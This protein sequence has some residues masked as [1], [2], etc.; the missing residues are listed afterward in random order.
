MLEFN[1]DRFLS[2]L[3]AAP[4][5]EPVIEEPEHS[6]YV[7][8]LIDTFKK[9]GRLDLTEINFDAFDLC[10]VTPEGYAAARPA[11]IASDRTKGRRKRT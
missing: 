1:K 5:I 11:G 8:S 7:Q 10:H 2:L 3:C 9:E 6:E 4:K